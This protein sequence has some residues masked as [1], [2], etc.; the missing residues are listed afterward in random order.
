MIA[1][2]LKLRRPAAPVTVPDGQRVYAVGDVHGCVDLLDELL[3]RID[4]DD[5]GRPAADT[6]LILLGDLVDRG[7][8]SSAVIERVRALQ[9]D[10]ARRVDVLM[11]NH[12]E[13]FLRAL[14]EEPGA[15][16]FFLRFGGRETLLSYGLFPDAYAD[17]DFVEIRDWLRAHMSADVAGWLRGLTDQVRIG[18]YLFVHA[19][20]RPGVPLDEQS[21]RD[22]RWIRPEFVDDPGDHGAMIVHGHTISDDVDERHNRIGLDTGAYSS[23]VLTAMGFEGTSRWVLQA[24]G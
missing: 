20:V 13:A 15:L 16:K 7:P 24:R 17:M 2:L 22:L 1:R 14:D 10:P 21:P 4:A 8:D 19:G 5:A 6:R 11:G 9:D 12:E 3:G 23:G 18:D